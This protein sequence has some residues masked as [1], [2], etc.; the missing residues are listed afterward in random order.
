[1]AVISKMKIMTRD[2]TELNPELL[3]LISKKLGNLSNFIRFRSVCKQ[4]RSA[5][6]PADPPPQLPWLLYPATLR[7]EEANTNTDYTLYSLSSNSSS[8]IELPITYKGFRYHNTKEPSIGFILVDQHKQILK[9]PYQLMVPY[10]FNPLTET[11]IH[12]PFTEVKYYF[13]L[14]MGPDNKSN[15]G[16]VKSGVHLVVYTIQNSELEIW[17]WRSD[18]NEITKFKIPFL[19]FVVGYYKGKIFVYLSET[20]E[21]KVF[22]MTTEAEMNIVIPHPV[23]CLHFNLFVEA[24]GDLLAVAYP[25]PGEGGR[26]SHQ[27]KVYRLE[28]T[29]VFGQCRWIKLKGI[30]E[31]VLF[32]GSPAAG[33]C[34]SASDFEGLR[35]NCIYYMR[36][37]KDVNE[38]DGFRHYNR[39]LRYD[40]ENGSSEELLNC[41]A[42][43]ATWFMPCLS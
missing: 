9:P 24:M 34:L 15:S 39:L 18:S 38:K 43:S 1:M 11:K 33:F 27:V 28:H 8:Q 23:E 42:L 5:A 7:R 30:G 16:M 4:W 21:T 25:H 36:D 12:L 6:D 32:L 10:L 40:M 13:S 2:W 31:R 22:D 41:V 35:G 3:H 19:T 14:Y 37:C 17:S 26:D 29:D 20:R